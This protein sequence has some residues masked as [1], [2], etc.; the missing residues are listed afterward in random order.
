[1]GSAEVKQPEEVRA[2]QL[3]DEVR[4]QGHQDRGQE[5]AVLPGEELGHGREG[6]QDHEGR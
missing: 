4:H 3:W 5:R 2:D 1:M 6:E